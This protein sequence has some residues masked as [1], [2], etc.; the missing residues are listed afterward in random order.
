M[1]IV[2]AAYARTS[3]ACVSWF[4]LQPVLESAV[5]RDDVRWLRYAIDLSMRAVDA[6][7]TAFVSVLAA[8]RRDRS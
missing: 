5:M 7:D 4:T 1:D 2:A 8:P 3:Y 6:G